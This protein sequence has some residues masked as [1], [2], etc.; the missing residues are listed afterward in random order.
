MGPTL[1]LPFTILTHA[2]VADLEQ[3]QYGT[4]RSD[5]SLTGASPRSD[6]HPVLLGLHRGRTTIQS[7]WSLTEVGLP[8]SLTGASPRSDYHPVS[9]KPHRGRTTIQS[10][11]SLTEVGLPSRRGGEGGRRWRA[12]VAADRTSRPRC[13]RAG[14]SVPTHHGERLPDVSQSWPGRAGGEGDKREP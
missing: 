8:S 13:R 3:Q 2:T 14:P 12:A 4:E 6:Y 11:W 1:M 10:H 7:H 9:L 5:G